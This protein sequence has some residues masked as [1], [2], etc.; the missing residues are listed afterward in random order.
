MTTSQKLRI[1]QK[2]LLIQ[3]MSVRLFIIFLIA[4]KYIF[5]CLI[6]NFYIFSMY[7]CSCLYR[8]FNQNCPVHRFPIFLKEKVHSRVIVS[9]IYSRIFTRIDSRFRTGAWPYVVKTFW[10]IYTEGCRA[11]AMLRPLRWLCSL[12]ITWITWK[13]EIVW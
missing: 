4:Y 12:V 1:A 6:F 5:F 13:L 8:D 2:K 7:N 11:N 10:L 9:G 3:K